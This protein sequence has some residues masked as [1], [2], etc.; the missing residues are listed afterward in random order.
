MCESLQQMAE[1]VNKTHFDNLVLVQHIT[2]RMQGENF[3]L[4]CPCLSQGLNQSS[5]CQK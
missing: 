2:L 1:Q 3:V 5:K 4:M